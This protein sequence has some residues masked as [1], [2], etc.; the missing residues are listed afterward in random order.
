MEKY[1]KKV[2]KLLRNMGYSPQDIARFLG[3]SAA[4]V[5]SYLPISNKGDEV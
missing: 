5:S 3:V 1:L 2:I 4:T